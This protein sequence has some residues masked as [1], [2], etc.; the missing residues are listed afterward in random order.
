MEEL[1]FEFTLNNSVIVKGNYKNCELLTK[2]IQ[3]RHL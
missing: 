1:D 3:I 2:P